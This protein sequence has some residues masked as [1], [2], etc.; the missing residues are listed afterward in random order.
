MNADPL[1]EA[2][3]LQI[4]AAAL[5]FDWRRLDELWA[6]LAEETDE[7]Q[8]AVAEGPDRV[9]DELGDLLFMAVNLARHLGVDAQ[10]ALAGANAK[11]ARRFAHVCSDLVGLSPIGDPR[12]LDEM[13]ARWQ[14]AKRAEQDR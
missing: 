13:E 4:E 14:D 9:Q 6:K 5:G 2:L 12:R 1:R 3:R 10:A 8:Q 11:F 7:L